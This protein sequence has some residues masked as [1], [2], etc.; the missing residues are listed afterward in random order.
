[1]TRQQNIESTISFQ[2]TFDSLK[3]LL[4]NLRSFCWGKCNITPKE[5]WVVISSRSNLSL[6]SETH[7]VWGTWWLH[8][9]FLVHLRCFSSCLFFLESLRHCWKP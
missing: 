4:E 3:Q 8:T 7:D 1:V 5:R 2:E 9:M 6:R